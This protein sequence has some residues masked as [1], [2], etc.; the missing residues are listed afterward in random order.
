MVLFAVVIDFFVCFAVR[1]LDLYAEEPEE[2]LNNGLVASANNKELQP[3][4]SSRSPATNN[5]NGEGYMK[6]LGA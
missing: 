5:L 3:M 2:D 4:M 6:T 1:G